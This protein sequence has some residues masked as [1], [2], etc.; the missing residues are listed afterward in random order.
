MDL[1]NSLKDRDVDGALIDS[2][3]VGS[4]IE[5]FSDGALRSS[6]MVDYS[7]AYGVVMAGYARKLQ[8]CFR[9]F[10]KE[11]KASVFKIITNNVQG[12][13]VSFE[14]W[15]FWYHNPSNQIYW[16][17]SVQSFHLNLRFPNAWDK[18]ERVD[19]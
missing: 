11:E 6:R 17:R 3:T 9:E 7:S 15:L 14:L 5:L 10:L 19:D 8:K 16:L 12:I 2:Y 18:H 1:Y 13:S 4:R